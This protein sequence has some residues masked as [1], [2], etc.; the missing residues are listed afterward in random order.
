MICN[1][2]QMRKIYCANQVGVLGSAVPK[3]ASCAVAVN[4]YKNKG[5]FQ[6]GKRYG[7][8][9][10]PKAVTWYFITQGEVLVM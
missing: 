7:G 10:T 5:R 2:L 1:A 3:T 9:Y 6:Y 8:S 4:W